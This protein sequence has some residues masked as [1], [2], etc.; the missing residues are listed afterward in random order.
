M[1][2]VTN[3]NDVKP[4]DFEWSGRTP[5]IA[6]KIY[7]T[8]NKLIVTDRKLEIG[9]EY[10]D[11]YLGNAQ[12]GYFYLIPMPASG[13]YSHSGE[14]FKAT[15]CNNPLWLELHTGES[16]YSLRFGYDSKVGDSYIV[17]IIRTS[18]TD[19]NEHLKVR[20]ADITHAATAGVV[21]GWDSTYVIESNDPEWNPATKTF[22]YHQDRIVQDNIYDEY[23]KVPAVGAADI[24]NR[25]I[26]FTPVNSDYIAR[27]TNTDCGCY[28]YDPAGTVYNYDKA[29]KTVTTDETNGVFKEPATTTTGCNE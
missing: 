10:R 16:D 29:T 2:T 19:A 17:P 13:T 5:E 12:D 14:S 4:S 22:R 25:Y 15:V 18:K 8:L 26:T 3:W 6:R 7:N 21:I 27:L 24:D 20:I 28:D 11:I 9:L 1:R 23:Y